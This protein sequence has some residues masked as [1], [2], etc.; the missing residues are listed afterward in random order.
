MSD[1]PVPGS[2]KYETQKL[3]SLT[4]Q[5]H[6]ITNKY[7]EPGSVAQQVHKVLSDIEILAGCTLLKLGESSEWTTIVNGVEENRTNFCKYLD[8]KPFFNALYG[9]YTV[10]LNELKAVSAQAKQSGAA[11]KTSSES[12]AQHDEFRE[13]KRRKRHNSSDNSQSVKKST[14][15][16]PTSA[17][18]KLPPKAV[19]TRNYFAPL[20]TTDMDTETTGAENTLP[21]QEAPRK[22]G[23]PPPIMITSSAVR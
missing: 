11:N 21:E 12:T 10:T 4:F 16:V 6:A 5:C 14:K 3:A 15:T 19:S 2:R 18:V 7:P 13:V 17:A 22:S 9:M 1:V 8:G 23:R 20:R